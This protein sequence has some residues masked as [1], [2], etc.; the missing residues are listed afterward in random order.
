MVFAEAGAAAWGEIAAAE[1]AAQADAACAALV[2]GLVVEV[3]EGEFSAGGE[4]VLALVY[5]ALG[6]GDDGAFE[7]GVAADL[8]VEAAVAGLEAALLGDTLVVALY[9]ALAGAEA[10]ADAGAD[11]EAAA[12]AL[13]FVVVV[14][15][16]LQAFDVEV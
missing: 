8:D 2:V 7:V 11:G 12:Q 9:F 6:A 1:C 15:A 10:A 16:V 13:L 4:G 3:T 5:C 14:A